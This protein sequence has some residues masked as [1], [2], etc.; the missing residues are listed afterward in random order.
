[1][2]LQWTIKTNVVSNFL[3]L[4]VQVNILHEE[5]CL[6]KWFMLEKRTSIVGLVHVRYIL[7]QDVSYTV[8]LMNIC[9]LLLIYITGVLCS[10]SNP[11]IFV[12]KTCMCFIHIHLQWD[13][14]S[15]AVKHLQNFQLPTHFCNIPLFL[16]YDISYFLK[17]QQ[18]KPPKNN[19]HEVKETGLISEVGG[20]HC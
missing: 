10:N 3:N 5:K 7:C 17:Q 20:R 6:L 4:S 18:K 12:I 13:C 16:S 2:D 1:M 15:Q 8:S 9:M 19:L 11:S 14:P